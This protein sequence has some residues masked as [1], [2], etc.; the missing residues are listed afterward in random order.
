MNHSSELR[1]PAGAVVADE[2]QMFGR[3]RT[4]HRRYRFLRDDVRHAGEIRLRVGRRIET[5]DM[6][7]AC[8]GDSQRTHGLEHHRLTT[9]GRRSRHLST[10]RNAQ[11][12]RSAFDCR[13][14]QRHHRGRGRNRRDPEVIEIGEEVL[15]KRL[16]EAPGDDLP[17][18]RED[19]NQRLDWR[20]WRPPIHAS[21]QAGADLPDDVG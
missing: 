4:G 17:I 15:V 18:A 9:I 11:T 20:I 1:I 6:A 3:L 12:G 14:R 13:E 8:A 19:L 7:Q 2:E 21:G 10:S 5:D 16:V